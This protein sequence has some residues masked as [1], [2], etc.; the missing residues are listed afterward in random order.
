M[1]H[2]LEKGHER[3][4]E[5]ARPHYNGLWSSALSLAFDD[6][7][8]GLQTG[9]VDLG[10]HRFWRLVE[11]VEQ[12]LEDAR[13]GPAKGRW[14]LDVTFGGVEHDEVDLEVHRR[15]QAGQS[16]AP[17]WIGSLTAFLEADARALP[18]DLVRTRDQGLLVLGEAPGG[19]WCLDDLG[20]PPG[21][22][23]VLLSRPDG[24][25]PR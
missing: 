1:P 22:A 18:A 12:R 23:V 19:R 3:V 5:L 8:S 17:I 4:E 11:S 14:R 6:F 16:G 20:P 9:R 13:L 7:A 2:A 25:A 24:S 21:Y 10:H 15:V